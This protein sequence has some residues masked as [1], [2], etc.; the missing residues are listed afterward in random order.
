MQLIKESGLPLELA[1]APFSEI[2]NAA[3]FRKDAAGEALRDKVDG[4]LAELAADG[5]LTRISDKW[6]GTDITKPAAE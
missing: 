5:T 2:R 3:P 4:A 6:F 1:G